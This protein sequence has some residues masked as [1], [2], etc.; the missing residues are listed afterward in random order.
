MNT[1]AAQSKVPLEFVKMYDE[2][3]SEVTWMHG[4]CLTYRELFAESPKRIELLNE[5]AGTFFYFVQ[6]V[7]MDEVQLVISK[8][9]DPAYSGK[10][11]N[12]SLE[13]LQLALNSYGDVKLAANCRSI[14]DQ[15]H[16]QC[17][18]I[19]IRRHKQL[20]HADLVTALKLATPLPGISRQMIEDALASVREFLNAIEI[21]YNDSEWAYEHFI[22]HHGAGALLATIRGGLRYE[23]LVKS[24]QIPY[25]DWRKSVWSDA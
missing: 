21:H 20:G 11:E 10:F 19:R 3:K 18:S 8:L 5:C 6:D 25:D 7:L 16:V 4:R 15:L 12:L 24:K 9:T 14:L 2:L 13:R 22:M 17:T 23:E 1:A